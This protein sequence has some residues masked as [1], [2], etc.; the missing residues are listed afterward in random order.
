MFIVRV[1]IEPTDTLRMRRMQ[2]SE[3]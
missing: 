1:I 3:C 2:I